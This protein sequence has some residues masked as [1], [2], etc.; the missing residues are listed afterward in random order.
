MCGGGEKKAMKH[1]FYVA[2][3]IVLCTC[4]VF[5]VLVER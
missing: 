3:G 1:I 2:N 4:Y 5:A